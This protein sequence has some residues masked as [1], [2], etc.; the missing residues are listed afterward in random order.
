MRA[1]IV[2]YRIAVSMGKMVAPFLQRGHFLVGYGT[3]VVI[4]DE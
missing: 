1:A 3:A 2:A 4:E